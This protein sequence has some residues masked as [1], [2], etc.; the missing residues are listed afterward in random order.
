MRRWLRELDRLLGQ[1]YAGRWTRAL[2]REQRERE[3]LFMLMLFSESLGVPNPVGW[4]T[5]ELRGP[6]LEDFHAW[7]RRQG[8]EKS[9]LD[10]VRCC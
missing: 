2:V 3:D 8:F 4:Y 9:P 7:H 10:D 6:L 1:V 5:L